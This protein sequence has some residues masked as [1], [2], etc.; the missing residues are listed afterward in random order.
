[1]RSFR[2]LTQDRSQK[3][4]MVGAELV[5]S[6]S[7]FDS[8][9]GEKV[10]REA[11]ELAEWGGV[12]WV[13]ITDN[14]GGHPMMAP[15]Y[16]G[17]RL[18][19]KDMDVIVHVT[20][21]DRNRNAI[22]SLLWQYD[23][24]GLKNILCLTGDFPADGY[25]GIGAPVFDLDST[26][27]LKMLADMNAGLKAPGRKPGSIIELPRTD[28]FTGA[29]VSPFKNNEA[30]LMCQYLKMELK[31]ESGAGFLIPQLGYDMRKSHELLIY[32]K[33]HGFDT[34][35]F[36]NIYILTRGVASVFNRKVI[37]GCVV[38]DKL[39]EDAKA[40]AKADDKGK[41]YFLE[42]AAKQ[43]ACFKGLGY[44]GAYI[45]GFMKAA[46]VKKVVELGEAYAEDDWKSFARD[47]VYPDGDD[48][49]L[50]ARDEDTGLAD[51]ERESPEVVAAAD[52]VD[53]KEITLMFHFNRFVHAVAFEPGGMLYKPVQKLYKALD[54][55]FPRTEK[56]MQ[57]QEKVFK[58]AMFNCQDCGDCSLFDCQYMCPG[59]NC[60]K[61]QRNGPCGG[62]RGPL[63][64]SADV[65]C[66]W[67]RAYHRAKKAGKLREF[68]KRDLV[69]R[70][71]S[72]Q[73]TSSWANF[74]TGRDHSAEA[75]TDATGE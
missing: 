17:R 65:P 47:L 56:F 64:E 37:P 44:R 68:L 69:L 58:K 19:D 54:G 50:F 23:A 60:K 72:L 63:C 3:P 62:S 28:F 25:H 24:E 14:A 34:P 39:L 26:T 21:K 27:L 22:E 48:F 51:P 30:E 61:N 2:D 12:D 11:D 59:A 6:R 15:S 71:Q 38:S 57:W 46:D 33:Q 1:M 5:T 75:G 10:V 36:G 20:C 35:V 7:N 16:I 73:G 53:P 18:L 49:Y 4:F 74:F 45:G 52:K 32:L 40:A 42:L 41:R 8:K 9:D 13:S 67:Y 55:K 29:A 70:D 66:M 31:I 43:Y